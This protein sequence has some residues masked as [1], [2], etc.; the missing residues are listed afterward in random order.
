LNFCPHFA[1]EDRIRN[2]DFWIAEVGEGNRRRQE[3]DCGTS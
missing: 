3:R 2:V 1:F